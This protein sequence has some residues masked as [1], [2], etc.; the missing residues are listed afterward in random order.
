MNMVRIFGLFCLVMLLVTPA[1]GA[2]QLEGFS[3]QNGVKEVQNT[4]PLNS[5]LMKLLLISAGVVFFLG[6]IALIKCG[7]ASFGGMIMG[8]PH[9][10]AAGLIGMAS[11][12]V[13]GISLTAGIALYLSWM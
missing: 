13:M 3:I 4:E 6:L 7:G 2:V 5:P 9:S 1:M 12:I 11:C 10:A 8:A